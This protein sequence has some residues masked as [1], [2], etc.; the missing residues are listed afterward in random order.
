M[1]PASLTAEAAQDLPLA[2]KQK[3]IGNEKS[4]RPLLIWGLMSGGLGRNRT[5][6]TRIFNFLNTCAEGFGP[7]T[8]LPSVMGGIQKSSIRA[9]KG[10]ATSEQFVPI[11]SRKTAPTSSRKPDIF[12]SHI[13]FLLIDKYLLA[14]IANLTDVS[15]KKSPEEHRKPFSWHKH[16]SLLRV[17]FHAK[18]RANVTIARC[19]RLSKI[20]CISQSVYD[21]CS[22]EKTEMNLVKRLGKG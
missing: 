4:P 20:C 18:C 5:A 17:D 14:H 8:D 7:D 6:D 15:I 10:L 12:R 11:W 22:L 21:N 9:T 1:K 16:R 19:T 13:L 3:R 2:S